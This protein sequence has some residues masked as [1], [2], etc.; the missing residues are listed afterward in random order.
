MGEVMA[1]DDEKAKLEAKTKKRLKLKLKKARL[2][3][4]S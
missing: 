3:F 2:A 1:S 4:F